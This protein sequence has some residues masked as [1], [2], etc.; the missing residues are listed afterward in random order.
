[1]GLHWLL[2]TLAF[3]F[4]RL[5]KFLKGQA[6]P[7]VRDGELN[8]SNLR[9]SHISQRDLSAAL[10]LAGK[11]ANLSQVSQAAIEANGDI[12]LM[13]GDRPPQVIEISVEAG[14]QTVRIQLE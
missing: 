2:A 3:Y 14:V 1:M 12:S 7:L 13:T 8:Q 5:E 10:R 6:L 9:Y 11:P 4:P